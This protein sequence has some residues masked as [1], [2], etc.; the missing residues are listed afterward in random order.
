MAMKGV[1][2]HIFSVRSLT[3]EFPTVNCYHSISRLSTNN[4]SETYNNSI[5]LNWL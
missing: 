1:N 4:T 2:M 5:L 3:V